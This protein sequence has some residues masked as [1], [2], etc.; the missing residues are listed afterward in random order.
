M[1][2]KKWDRVEFTNGKKGVVTGTVLKGGAKKA[3]VVA[4]GGKSEYD[5]PVQALRPTT[6]AAPKDEPSSLDR[7]GLSGYKEA[8]GEDTVCFDAYVTFDGKRVLHAR[9]SGTGGSNI[10]Q[11]LE[12]GGRRHIDQLDADAKAFVA[13]N[14]GGVE[15][16]V[17]DCWL[18]WKS[19]FSRFQTFAS[20][21]ADWRADSKKWDEAPPYDP[22]AAAK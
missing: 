14:G 2:V 10:Y 12:A 17:I 16:E 19:Y 5:V 21:L 22:A 3:R 4:D 6:V 8:G 20:Y 9:N 15:Y 18:G 11:P 13:A 7:W 1:A